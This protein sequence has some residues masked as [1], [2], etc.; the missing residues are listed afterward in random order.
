MYVSLN[1]SNRDE[2]Q[3][4][5]HLTMYQKIAR[6]CPARNVQEYKHFKLLCSFI[7][8]HC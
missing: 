7:Y 8:V 6:P 1:V 2:L 3:L 5:F 4:S